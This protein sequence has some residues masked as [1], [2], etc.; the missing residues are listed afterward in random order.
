MKYLFSAKVH[1]RDF[2][3]TFQQIDRKVASMAGQSWA[4]GLITRILIWVEL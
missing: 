3:G 2:S 4:F 1:F